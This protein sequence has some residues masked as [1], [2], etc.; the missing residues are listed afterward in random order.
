MIW[1]SASVAFYAVFRQDVGSFLLSLEHAQYIPVTRGYKLSA[2]RFC[3]MPVTW[4]YKSSASR[5][6]GL[7]SMSYGP[8]SLCKA[9]EPLDKDP[10]ES[11]IFPN[12]HPNILSLRG[13]LD[14]GRDARM[15]KRDSHNFF[16]L[17]KGIL[18]SWTSGQRSLGGRF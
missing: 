16:D 2:G 12:Y 1:K 8:N 9:S 4:G 5:S 6:F 15:A 18:A 3:F 17:T 11:C 13:A 10:S 7:R 14:H